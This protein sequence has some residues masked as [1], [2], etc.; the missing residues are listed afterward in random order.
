MTHTSALRKAPQ[1]VDIKMDFRLPPAVQKV[2]EIARQAEATPPQAPV[3]LSAEQKQAIGL[4]LAELEAAERALI[5]LQAEAVAAPTRMAALIKR[6]DVKAV[7]A[8]RAR[9]EALPYEIQTQRIKVTELAMK[10]RELQA[11]AV[12][13]ELTPIVVDIDRLNAELKRLKEA[14][15]TLSE[16]AAFL[17]HSLSLLEGPIEQL[18]KQKA[19]G[20][21]VLI[22]HTLVPS[23][24]YGGH[25][26]GADDDARPI[27][28]R[29][30]DEPL[31]RM[32]LLYR[33]VDS[34]L[35]VMEMTFDSATV[36]TSEWGHRLRRLHSP[37]QQLR[38]DIRDARNF[39]IDGELTV[40][41]PEPR[42]LPDLV[43][44]GAEATVKRL[45]ER[46]ER[47]LGER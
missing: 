32:L 37:L 16:R 33:Q 35:R 25:W 18:Q 8:F 34:V 19:A 27:W 44:G 28:A 24:T 42:E 7:Q 46:A 22:G 10:A 11:E 9:H 13:A 47:L 3:E 5:E 26:E 36:I 21:Q 12:R 41:R 20:W 1:Y 14:Q 6:G 38:N 4:A 40:N 31:D 45:Y 30:A 17:R 15:N 2:S 39:F 29:Q 23:A 43:K